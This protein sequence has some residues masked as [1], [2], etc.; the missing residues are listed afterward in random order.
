MDYEVWGDI[1]RLCKD[2]RFLSSSKRFVKPW[3]VISLHLWTSQQIHLIR[4]ST[5]QNRDRLIVWNWVFWDLHRDSSSLDPWCSSSCKQVNKN[6]VTK[7]IYHPKPRRM[8]CKELSFWR[9]SQRYSRPRSVT[10]FKLWTSESNHLTR[11]SY[12]VKL[13]L[14][15]CK[16][17][18]PL[19]PSLR[20]LRPWSVIF[21]Q[22]WAS[23]QTHLTE[24]DYLAKSSLMECKEV[25]LLRHSPREYRPWSVIL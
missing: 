5:I 12:P 20:W 8:D 22:L 1:S 21:L 24:F 16:E 4:P 6:Y 14:M 9:H 2:S 15:N 7:I 18:S 13:R 25:S 17:S 3:C 19:R 11:D 23:Q 10:R